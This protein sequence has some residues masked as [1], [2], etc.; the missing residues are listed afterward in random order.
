[1]S[2]QQISVNLVPGKKDD[3]NRL[4]QTL[5]EIHGVSDVKIA[6]KQNRVDIDAESSVNVQLIINEINMKTGFKA[7]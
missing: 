7:F 3:E 5:K 1:M 2:L 4:L 6:L